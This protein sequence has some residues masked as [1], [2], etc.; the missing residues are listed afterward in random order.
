ME[1][2]SQIIAVLWV[3]RYMLTEML[4]KPG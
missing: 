3:Q 4:G 1:V 2:N